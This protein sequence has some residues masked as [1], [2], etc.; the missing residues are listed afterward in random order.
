MTVEEL[1]RA[2]EQFEVVEYNGRKYTVNGLMKK[3][4]V[5]RRGNLEWYYAVELLDKNRWS[6]VIADPDKVSRTGEY[7]YAR[8]YAS[9]Y[10]A[11][12]RDAK[13]LEEEI[14]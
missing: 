6:V 4:R 13:S 2:T 11:I 10:A 8:V 14:C 9:Q 5:N 1:T 3:F 7:T 12:T